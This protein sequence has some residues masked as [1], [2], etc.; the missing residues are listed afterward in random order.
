MPARMI[1]VREYATAEEMRAAY[2][3]Q[4]R[5]IWSVKAPAP[6]LPQ[7]VIIAA[8]PPPTKPPLRETQPFTPE[9]LEAIDKIEAAT[10]LHRRRMEIIAEEA[11]KAGTTVKDIL[12]PA[13]FE[14]IL[15]ARHAAILR[16]YALGGLNINGM[17]RLFRKDHTTILHCLT[18]NGMRVH[19]TH[20]PHPQQSKCLRFIREYINEHGLSPTYE[21]IG[22]AMGIAKS[23]VFRLIGRIEEQGH[24]YR[25]PKCHRSIRL[26][27]FSAAG[28]LET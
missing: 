22:A 28:G 23:A 6:I 15:R 19:T 2:R 18:I 9:E 3:E 11:A 12:G 25:L 1:S 21:E 8:P 26:A 16:V 10:A 24:L 5:K 13:R 14:Y 17:G 7:P 20:P 4:Q 27:G